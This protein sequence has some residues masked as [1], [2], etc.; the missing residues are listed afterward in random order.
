MIEQLR[1][2]RDRLTAHF[3]DDW[4]R[5]LHWGS[6]RLH[7]L[8]TATIFPALGCIAENPSALKDLVAQLPPRFP[9]LSALVVL[10]G[11]WLFL[12]W[13]VRVWNGKPNG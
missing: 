2:W 12:G 10:G 11:A 1:A 5:S 6:V 7:A 3:V 8:A 9:F 13:L 4:H